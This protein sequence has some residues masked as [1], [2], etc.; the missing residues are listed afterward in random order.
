MRRL[1]FLLT[2]IL[3]IAGCAD[4]DEQAGQGS[5]NMNGM[6]HI[7]RLLSVSII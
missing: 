4:Q 7:K 6:S 5:E 2:M 1:I 3:V